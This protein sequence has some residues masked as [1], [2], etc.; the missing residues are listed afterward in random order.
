LVYDEERE[1]FRFVDG[2]FA[3]SREYAD[4]ELLRRRDRMKGS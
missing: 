3:F 1:R 4:W 2:K